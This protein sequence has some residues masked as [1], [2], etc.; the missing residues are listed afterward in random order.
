M[1]KQPVWDKSCVISRAE[2]S[3]V[4][5]QIAAIFHAAPFGSTIGHGEIEKIAGSRKVARNYVRI[6]KALAL[7]NGEWGELFSSVSNVG[8]RKLFPHEIP[9]RVREFIQSQANQ[10]AAFKERVDNVI[11]HQY[12]EEETQ[13]K[14]DPL[15]RVI[16]QAQT[17]LTVTIAL[18]LGEKSAKKKGKQTNDIHSNP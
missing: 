11:E 5:T 10:M 13:A 16:T 17:A 3:S 12:L 4:I 9:D 15:C 2:S 1:A 6:R 8:Y 18:T 14:L 7:C